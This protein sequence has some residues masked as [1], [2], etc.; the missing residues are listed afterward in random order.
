M[1]RPQKAAGDSQTKGNKKKQRS[2]CGKEKVNYTQLKL[3][4][5]V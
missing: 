1:D 3:N 5:L 4:S 2:A